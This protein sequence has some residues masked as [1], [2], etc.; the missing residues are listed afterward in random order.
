MKLGRF[1]SQSIC[2]NVEDYWP[3]RC[4]YLNEKKLLRLECY[5]LTS[6]QY[7]DLFQ[8]KTPADIDVIGIRGLTPT[9]TVPKDIIFEHRVINQINLDC[10]YSYVEQQYS[11]TIHPEAFRSSR[12]FTMRMSIHY[13][14]LIMFNF[15]FL[16]G[17]TKL[18]DLLFS[19]CINFHLLN[20]PQ[21]PNLLSV[22][23]YNCT[24]LNN[25]TDFPML[26]I[27]LKTLVL[28]DNQLSNDDANRILHWISKSPS[29]R[30]LTW[31]ILAKNK[32]TQIPSEVKSFLHLYAGL[33]DREDSNGKF[34][35]YFE[36][37]L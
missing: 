19:D 25:W 18:E 34:L 27:R 6:D 28:I 14:D 3:C 37:K 15:S 29:Y 17:F 33:K 11:T 12:N 30:T 24:G 36:R 5:R 16:D 13:C 22:R 26:K 8:Y 4:S 21:L 9:L 10:N 7:Y 31:L 35:F 20:L 32:L 2:P 23:V 1:V